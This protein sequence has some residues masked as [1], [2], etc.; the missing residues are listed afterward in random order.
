M[1]RF[2]HISLKGSGRLSGAFGCRS[3]LISHYRFFPKNGLVN[4]DQQC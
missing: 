4:Q 3:F 1:T 2:P